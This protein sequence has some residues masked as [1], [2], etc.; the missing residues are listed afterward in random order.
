[1]QIAEFWKF[2]YCVNKYNPTMC[3]NDG[4]MQLRIFC[5]L[6]RSNSMLNRN[7]AVPLHNNLFIASTPKSQQVFLDLHQ[8]LHSSKLKQCHK[9]EFASF[10][11]NYKSKAI[12]HHTATMVK[13]ERE[14]DTE[15]NRFP[16]VGMVQRMKE[17]LWVIQIFRRYL[18]YR[19][20]KRA[21]SSSIWNRQAYRWRLFVFFWE[22]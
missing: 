22:S 10:N 12:P 5:T 14:R 13:D 4:F 21:L 1:M 15:Y 7:I 19:T 8:D 9:Q 16:L 2:C 18:Y 11:C 17:A 3:H 20:Y 6:F